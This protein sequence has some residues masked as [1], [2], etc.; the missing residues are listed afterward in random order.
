MAYLINQHHQSRIYLRDYHSFGRLAY[1]VTTFL[2]FPKVSR[3][4]A[5]IEWLDDHWSIRDLSTNGL[6]LNGTKCTKEQS[7]TLK[8]NDLLCFANLEEASFKVKDIS[9][10]QDL[11]LCLDDKGTHVVDALPLQPY[12]LLPNE[13]QPQMV[14]FFDG[15]LKSWQLENLQSEEASQRLLKEQ[16]SFV[17]NTRQW[18]L[19]TL[20]HVQHTEELPVDTLS[21]NDLLFDF[22]LSQDEETTELNIVVEDKTFSLELRT[23]H[24]VTLLLARIK[25]QDIGKQLPEEEQGWIYTDVLAHDLGVEVNHLNILIHRARKQFSEAFSGYLDASQFLQRKAGKLRFGGVQFRINKGAKQEL[26]QSL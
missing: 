10:P 7:Y 1:S 13:E 12:N 22:D 2:A 5:V 21:I 3:I 14:L 6:W 15:R 17:I 23:H 16:D 18:R 8:K 24:Y 9:P 11:L 26:W 25:F 20:Q 4:H 19:Q